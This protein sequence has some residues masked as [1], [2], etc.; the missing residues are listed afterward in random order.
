MS[1]FK[2]GDRVRVTFEGEWR[3]GPTPSDRVS[4]INGGN[5]P[6]DSRYNVTVEKVE[7]PFEPGDFVR[8]KSSDRVFYIA[9]DGYVQVTPR[10]GTF[11]KW[12]EYDTLESSLPHD[13]GD[14]ERV[15]YAQVPF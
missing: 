11:Q 4:Y 6:I 8:E 5:V 15:E 2:N 7:P 1:D 12:D 14:Y 10:P 9:A 3:G 13:T